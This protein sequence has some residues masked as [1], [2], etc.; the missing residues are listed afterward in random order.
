MR[1]AVATHSWRV[2]DHKKSKEVAP[3][4]KLETPP[5]V[6]RLTETGRDTDG[7]SLG[8][9]QLGLLRFGRVVTHTASRL[10]GALGTQDHEVVGLNDPLGV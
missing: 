1:R 4:W 6:I 3:R 2:H 9:A 5:D 10:V 7:V 8:E